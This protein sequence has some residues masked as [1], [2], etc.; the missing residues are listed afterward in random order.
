MNIEYT[1][2]INKKRTIFIFFYLTASDPEHSIVSDMHNN[3]IADAHTI[4]RHGVS[5][6]AHRLKSVLEVGKWAI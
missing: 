1:N 3:N 2:Q 4:S 5:I 6:Q